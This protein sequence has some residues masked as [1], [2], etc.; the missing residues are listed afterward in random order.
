MA[1]LLLELFS[2][3]IPAR[4]QARAASDLAR[5]IGAGLKAQGLEGKI[6]DA[7]AGPRRLTLV[8]ADLPKK[9]PDTSDERKGPQVG[10]P[11]A[12]I[13]GFLRASGLKRIDDAEVR[14]LSKGKFYFAVTKK[15]GRATSVVV[16]EV[17]E[18]ALPQLPWPKSMRWADNPT[19]WVRPLHGILCLLEGKVV[20][21]K[22]AGVKA[23]SL[24][25]GHRFLAP[26]AIQIKSYADYKVKLKKAFVMADPEERAQVIEDGL[27]KLAAKE[28]LK[29][30]KDPGLLAEV[31]GLI[32]WPVPLLGT[33]D[34]EFMDVP[35]EVLT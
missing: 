12:A 1:E 34:S 21:V 33:I 4:M 14:E 2:E 9:Q 10:A 29:I 20:P 18:A 28:N 3:E 8:V 13:Q 22:F 15:K 25:K 11:D 6:G 26:K 5:L 32:E 16:K 19:R 27:A 31:A 24:T 17:I 23:G 35:P 7:F 30:K